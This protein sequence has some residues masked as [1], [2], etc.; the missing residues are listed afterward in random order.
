[1]LSNRCEH[2]CTQLDLRT[3]V[4]RMARCIANRFHDRVEIGGLD[5]SDGPAHMVAAASIYMASYLLDD[6]RSLDL[7]SSCDGLEVEEVRRVYGLLYGYRH[8]LISMELLARAGREW[9]EVEEILPSVM[10]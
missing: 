7:V 3:V 2:L 8:E 5:S 4:M 1:M 10:A 6:V 9:E